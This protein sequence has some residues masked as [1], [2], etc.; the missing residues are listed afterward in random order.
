MTQNARREEVKRRRRGVNEASLMRYSTEYFISSS[1][2]FL[3]LHSRYF[4]FFVLTYF[5][6]TFLGGRTDRP[7]EYF[8]VLQAGGGGNWREINA[9][10][11]SHCAKFP[12]VAQQ[13]KKKN[14][15]LLFFSVHK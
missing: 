4:F 6:I 1:I 2:L 7:A 12:F 3:L 10:K 8:S 9:F 14:K 15:M 11:N 13:G 5:Y